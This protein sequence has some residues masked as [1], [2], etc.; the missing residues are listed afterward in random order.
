[1]L[2]GLVKSSNINQNNNNKGEKVKLLPSSFYI[3]EGKYVFTEEFHLERGS[4]CGNGCR[5]C[6]YYPKH[7]KGN[8]TK[9]DIK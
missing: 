5:E 8:T 2:V 9:E 6:P 3:E 1:V 7:E 4:C